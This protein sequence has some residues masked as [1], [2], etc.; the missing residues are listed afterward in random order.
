MAERKRELTVSFSPS[1]EQKIAIAE[2]LK[3][4]R[5]HGTK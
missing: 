3:K 4:A 2:R 5:G 1:K